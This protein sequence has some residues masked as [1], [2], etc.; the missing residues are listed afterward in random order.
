MN[1]YFSL[2]LILIFI[3]C[4]ISIESSKGIYSVFIILFYYFISYI[5]TNDFLVLNEINLFSR[6]YLI[7]DLIALLGSIDFV[8]G[9]VDLWIF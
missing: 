8:L 9:S 5:I 7:G 4:N 6:Y 1:F 2:L 3:H